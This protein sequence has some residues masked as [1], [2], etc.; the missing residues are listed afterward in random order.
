MH[1]SHARLTTTVS[2]RERAQ[3]VLL[4]F[5]AEQNYSITRGWKGPGK[6]TSPKWLLWLA[7]SPA[8][9]ELMVLVREE[10]LLL[11]NNAYL[12]LWT[13]AQRVK[14]QV[15]QVSEFPV[16]AGGFSMTKIN[17]I[18]THGRQMCTAW[19]H[20]S[21][22][23]NKNLFTRSFPQTPCCSKMSTSRKNQPDECKF[24]KW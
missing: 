24:Y 11:L 19:C 5:A 15:S 1:R 7:L 21:L 17:H 2:R 14:V 16:T 8:C 18:C 13:R 4:L 6:G 20:A 23:C 22:P 12:R 3:S 10:D 9:A